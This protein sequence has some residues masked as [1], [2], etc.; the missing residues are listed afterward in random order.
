[1][2]IGEVARDLKEPARVTGCGRRPP[3]RHQQRPDAL[4]ALQ[5]KDMTD[6]TGRLLGRLQGEICH[7]CHGI[8]CGADERR[9]PR[10]IAKYSRSRATSGALSGQPRRVVW[11]PSHPRQKSVPGKMDFRLIGKP[12]NAL[13]HRPGTGGFSP[14]PSVSPCISWLTP[15]G[16]VDS[17]FNMLSISSVCCLHSVSVRD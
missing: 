17:A 15:W 9:S 5:F 12:T 10:G 6:W 7:S 16:E 13:R 3:V 2:L 14:R 11:M 8:R 4:C 1:M